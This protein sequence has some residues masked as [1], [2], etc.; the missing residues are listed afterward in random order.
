MADDQSTWHVCLA[1]FLSG[2]GLKGSEGERRL[3][4]KALTFAEVAALGQQTSKSAVVFRS[5]D[6]GPMMDDA[7]VLQRVSLT[8]TRR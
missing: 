5:G 1:I 3:R 8:T 7:E 2:Q 4:M 6:P